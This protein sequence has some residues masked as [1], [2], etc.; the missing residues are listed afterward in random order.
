MANDKFYTVE[1]E[2]NG[3]KYV[4]QF[5]GLSTGLKIMDE[6]YIDGSDNL[7]TFKLAERIFDRIIVEPKGLS[8]DDFDTIKEFNEVITWAQDVMQGNFRTETKQS[9]SKKKG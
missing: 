9:E 1:K 2:I 8:I 5:S 3:K 4:A 6:C 7:S